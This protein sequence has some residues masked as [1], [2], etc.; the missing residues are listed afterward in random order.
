MVADAYKKCTHFF[1]KQTP[2][3]QHLSLSIFHLVQYQ[4]FDYHTT[5]KEYS[6]SSSSEPHVYLDVVHQLHL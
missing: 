4:P 6:T 1:Y 5:S 3:M 2:E